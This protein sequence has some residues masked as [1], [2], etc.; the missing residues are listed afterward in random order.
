MNKN[1][2]INKTAFDATIALH[3][4]IGYAVS[5]IEFYDTIKY[6][7]KT[8]IQNLKV[9]INSTGG[10]VFDGYSIVTALLE[11]SLNVTTCNDGIAA[12]MAGIILLCGKKRIAKDY[13]VW[14][15][16][17]PSFGGGGTFDPAQKAILEKIKASL[18]VICESNGLNQETISNMMTKETWMDASE[19]LANG[20]I[21]SIEKTTVKKPKMSDA[22]ALFEVYN[23]I[24]NKKTMVKVT[25]HFGLNN[26]A[27]EDAIL[28]AIQD[29][30]KAHNS[31]L[32][33]LKAEK[34]AI[35][36]ELKEANTALEA[37]LKEAEN[38]IAEIELAEKLAKEEAE[39]AELEAKETL[40]VSSVEDAIKEGK[41]TNEAKDE[42]L[43][44]AKS[45]I[46]VFNKILTGL[47]REPI[48]ISNVID[49]KKQ[50]GKTTWTIRDYEINAPDELKNIM[51]NDPER[52]QKM[53]NEFYN[54]T[55]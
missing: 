20:I 33:T 26:E 52:Y 41:I 46:N 22:K 21:D 47:K 35:E 28:A 24:L 11:T 4:E 23:S 9:S 38:K 2:I 16:H 29:K 32:E 54:K 15:C 48:K 51:E 6:L 5:G 25:N 31:A 14:M 18:L 12:S 55:K 8:G 34:E 3:G 1:I 7:E 37:K 49:N 19:M 36:S 45:D 13:A 40:A 42:F 44:I 43:A 27:N 39:K 50:E 30:D 10:S 17:D 53:V